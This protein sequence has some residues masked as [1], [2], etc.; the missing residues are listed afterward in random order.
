MNGYLMNGRA[1]TQPHHKLCTMQSM[2]DDE[3][4]KGQEEEEACQLK[5]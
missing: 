2:K 5:D 1:T 4:V 3:E